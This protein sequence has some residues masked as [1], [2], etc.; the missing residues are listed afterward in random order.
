MQESTTTPEPLPSRIPN[1]TPG[2]TSN[3]QD[4]GKTSHI[5]TNTSGTTTP[6]VL[7][8]TKKTAILTSTE[9][10]PTTN[11]TMRTS[12]SDSENAENEYDNHTPGRTRKDQSTRE[13]DGRTT[14][15][16][17]NAKTEVRDNSIEGDRTTSNTVIND[18][19]DTRSVS[20]VTNTRQNSDSPNSGEVST[21][22][23]TATEGNV[24]TQSDHD[25]FAMKSTTKE[26][27]M[28]GSHRSSSEVTPISSATKSNGASFSTVHTSTSIRKRRSTS[29]TKFTSS[30]DTDASTNTQTVTTDIFDQIF[31][32]GPETTTSKDNTTNQQPS[33]ASVTST[34]TN[35]SAI[36]PTKQVSARVS[37]F[38]HSTDSVAV[39]PSL[40]NALGDNSGL[41][42]SDDNDI[43]RNHVVD[44]YEAENSNAKMVYDE[45]VPFK[46]IKDDDL[47]TEA[48][49]GA[50][51]GLFVSFPSI[52]ILFAIIVS[53]IAIVVEHIRMGW[54]NLKSGISFH[55]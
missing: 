53:D 42:R 10:V 50:V 32:G 11:Y 54:R 40:S 1:T 12:F 25:S 47:P 46:H 45:E 39:Q 48:I 4:S 23:A 16:T 35:E 31:H 22:H 26:I 29:S 55:I 51:I 24:K 44:T 14:V 38:I 13:S 28:S 30:D 49:S 33:T 6:D 8:S 19:V 36:S 52:I 17:I 3:N 20:G 41:Q 27:P 2:T 15:S 43:G 18:Q 37:K 5:T 7:T 21:T 9:V 34:S